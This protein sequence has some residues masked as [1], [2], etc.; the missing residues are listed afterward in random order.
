MGMT[1]LQIYST[2][3]AYYCTHYNIFHKLSLSS[4][5]CNASIY[6][7]CYNNSISYAITSAH[8]LV[9]DN[10]T[11]LLYIEIL[12]WVHIKSIFLESR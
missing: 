12:M 8:M 7:T 10:V 1:S 5:Q 3:L 9:C 4:T 11:V 2:F 6:L